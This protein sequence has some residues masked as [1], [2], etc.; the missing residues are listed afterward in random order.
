MEKDSRQNKRIKAAF[1]MRLKGV[2][3]HGREF[4]EAV[5]TVNISKSGA[6]IITNR[7]LQVGSDV[8]L[9]IPLPATII[10]VEPVPGS[11]ERKYAVYFR[12]FQPREEQPAGQ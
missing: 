7:E 2:D 8:Q 9:A 1:Y 5:R 11:G 12:P 3:G 6:C 4:E 10:R